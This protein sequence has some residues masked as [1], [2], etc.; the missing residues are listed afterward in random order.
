MDD[1]LQSMFADH[2]D[3]SIHDSLN[4]TVIQTTMMMKKAFLDGEQD[5]PAP[6]EDSDGKE[7]GI[8]EETVIN[9]GLL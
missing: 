7:Q 8:L 9:K 5:Q 1:H 4:S 3:D 2:N 6:E